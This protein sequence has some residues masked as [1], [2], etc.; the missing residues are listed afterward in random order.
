MVKV[1]TDAAHLS[2]KKLPIIP[3]MV[4]EVDIITGHKSVLNYLLKPVLR[5]KAQALSER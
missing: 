1:K 4:A 2:E 3:G 5:A